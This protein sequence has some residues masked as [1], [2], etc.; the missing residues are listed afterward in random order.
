MISLAA[1]T[2]L[3][4]WSK[5]TLWRRISDGTVARLEDASAREKVKIP[6][7]AIRSYACI[8]LAEQ[9]I[10]LIEQADSGDAQAQ[11]ELATIFLTYGKVESAIYWLKLAVKQ[12]HATAMYILGRCY[13]DGNGIDRNCDLGIMWIAN[14]ASAG[15]LVAQAQMAAMCSSLIGA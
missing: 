11:T 6:F 7:D 8:P 14:A 2:T 15:H 3:T 13:T 5:R 10:A 1:A 9:D 12:D 4:E